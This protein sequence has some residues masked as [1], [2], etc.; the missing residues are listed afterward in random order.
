MTALPDALI[1]DVDGTLADTEEAHR[2]SFNQTFEHFGLGWTWDPAEYRDLL[3][4]TGGKERLAA[5][6][7]RLSAPAR[8]RDAWRAQIP[9]WHAEKTR[10]Y[11]ELVGSG[12]V[13]LRPG[14]ARLLSQAMEAGVPLAIATTTTRAN[15]DALL[16]AQLGAGSVSLFQVVA[17]GDEV[18]NKK[19]AP[20]IYRLALN[21]LGVQP[22]RAIAF[23][24]SAMG[25][26]A[27]VAAGL[28][29]VVTP[30]RWTEGSD[31]LDAGLVLPS[32]DEPGSP[33]GLLIDLAQAWQRSRPTARSGGAPENRAMP[34]V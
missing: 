13:P 12:Q 32:L 4:V 14:V 20:D 24:D 31:F 15:I 34:A 5:Y 21:R 22:E 23:E 17:C 3:A 11:T 28:W 8:E 25:L 19:P 10:R 27:A 6:L 33:A 29:T 18:Q 1:F 26:Q 7:D 9:A 16:D 30:N 2:L